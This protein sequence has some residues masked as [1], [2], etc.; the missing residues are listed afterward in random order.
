MIDIFLTENRAEHKQD[1]KRLKDSIADKLLKKM[2]I[3]DA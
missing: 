2:M 3:I 1:F